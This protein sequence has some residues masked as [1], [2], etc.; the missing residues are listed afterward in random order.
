ES[1]AAHDAVAQRFDDFT[2]FDDRLDVDTVAGA[3]IVFA[4]ND[5]L[6]YVAKPPGQVARIGRLQR[7]IGQTLAGAVGRD[8]VLQHIQTFAE[9]SRNRLLDDFAGGLGHQAAHTG[10]LPDLLLRAAG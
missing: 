4:N 9:V 7:G 5:V 1:D 10:K 3:A 2:G 8:E 6:R